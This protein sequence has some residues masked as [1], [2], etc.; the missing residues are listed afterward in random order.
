MSVLKN[1]GFGSRGKAASP[2]APTP[3]MYAMMGDDSPYESYAPEDE[4]E[5]APGVYVPSAGM[6]GMMGAGGDEGGTS[7]AD[8]KKKLAGF[9][10]K[11]GKKGGLLDP[12]I[13]QGVM[14]GM[15]RVAPFSI[16]GRGGR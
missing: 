6:E 14:Q 10:K 3:G 16:V 8:W 13:T 11:Q 15:P 7:F 4:M 12:D 9:G 1:L 2:Y 5:G